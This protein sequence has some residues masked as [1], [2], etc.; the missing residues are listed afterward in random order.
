[1]GK[2]IYSQLNQASSIG[3]D[4]GKLLEKIIIGDTSQYAS[5]STAM[6]SLSSTASSEAEFQKLDKVLEDYWKRNDMH[7][8]VYEAKEIKQRANYM[9]RK[10]EYYRYKDAHHQALDMINSNYKISGTDKD[11]GIQNIN[12]IDVASWN[13]VKI[14][15]ELGKVN[16]IK[17]SLAYAKN[18]YNYNPKDT[19]HTTLSIARDIDT[20]SKSLMAALGIAVE[21]NEIPDDD[22]LLR[23][24]VSGRTD[25]VKEHTDE[26][27][28]ISAE[29][30]KT[31]DGNVDSL[32]NLHDK[33]IS[34]KNKTPAEFIGFIDRATSGMEGEDAAQI[35]NDIMG[36]EGFN[37]DYSVY[38][39]NIEVKM[40]SELKSRDD[41]NKR[42]KK[43]T[44]KLYEEMDDSLRKKL[45]ELFGEGVDGYDIDYFKGQ[46]GK[47]AEVAKKEKEAKLTAQKK[48]DEA[49]KEIPDTSA[50]VIESTTVGQPDISP[51]KEKELNF[52]EKERLRRSKERKE[53][54]TS[55]IEYNRKKLANEIK[56]NVTLAPLNMYLDT[57]ADSVGYEISEVPKSQKEKYAVDKEIRKSITINNPDINKLYNSINTS[58]NKNSFAKSLIKSWKNLDYN[59][60]Y[61]YGS[62]SNFIKGIIEDIG[63]KGKEGYDTEELKIEGVIK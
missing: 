45:D 24:I 46:E 48:I 54:E 11:G 16:R 63:T 21:T 59:V 14:T 29:R 60:K 37:L 19:S 1:M 57:V 26:Q 27:Q 23:H 22:I 47:I 40:R 41:A 30:Y 31:H 13:H 33:I 32:D 56:G 49:R 25:K 42:H 58:I 6:D 53:K 3:A 17:D 7:G 36:E 52:I 12:T 61:D 43:Y 50:A 62:F 38:A 18:G 9:Q 15:E 10:D 2:S 4:F 51:K 55:A 34:Y 20:Y 44:G 35:F 8:P 39:K 5:E 28:R